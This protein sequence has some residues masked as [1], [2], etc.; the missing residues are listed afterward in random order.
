M[1]LMD[2][3][4]LQRQNIDFC[5]SKSIGLLFFTIKP[6]PGDLHMYMEKAVTEIRSTYNPSSSHMQS[7]PRLRSAPILS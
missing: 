3:S 2:I 1:I 5:E 4:E 7:G 6:S